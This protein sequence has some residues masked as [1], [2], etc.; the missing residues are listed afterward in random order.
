MGFLESLQNSGFAT[1]V[2]ESPSLLAYQLHIT[3]HTIGLGMLVGISA[4]IC[5]RI[6]GVA[7]AL[8]LAPMEKYL[9]FMWLGF[10][11]NAASGVVLFI[12]EPVK[13]LTIPVFYIK[14]GSIAVALVMMSKISALVFRGRT[15]AGAGPAPA[16]AKGLAAVVLAAWFVAIISGRVTAYSPA[17]QFQTAAAVLILAVVLAIGGAIF[18]RRGTEER[19][20]APARRSHA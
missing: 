19:A 4:G 1:W 12:L 13:F 6:L 18:A 9:R 5:F 11:I 10:W 2:R 17:I 14:I 7:A 15:A 20:G 16:G 3:L 8:P